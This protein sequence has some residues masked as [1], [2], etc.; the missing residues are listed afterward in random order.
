MRHKRLTTPRHRAV[1][2]SRCPA[3]GSVRSGTSPPRLILRNR[4]P[5]SFRSAGPGTPEYLN[6]QRQREVAETEAIWNS[7]HDPETYNS[8]N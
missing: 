3:W 1:V 6:S 8:D 7:V 2:S 5:R 4:A